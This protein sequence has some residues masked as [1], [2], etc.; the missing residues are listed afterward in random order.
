MSP[1][2]PSSIFSYFATNW[3]FTKPKGSPILQFWAL[4]TAPILAVP[5]LLIFQWDL[6]DHRW[7]AGGLRLIAN[8]SFSLK[9]YYLLKDIPS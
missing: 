5:G 1:N 9:I 3:S 7:A 2:G 6:V 4:D 8:T